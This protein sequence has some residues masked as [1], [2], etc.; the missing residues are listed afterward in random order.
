[1]PEFAKGILAKIETMAANAAYKEPSSSA[2]PQ[3]GRSSSLPERCVLEIEN[4]TNPSKF[5]LRRRALALT[6]LHRTKSFSASATTKV[7]R[8]AV[9][10]KV[11]PSSCWLG[12]FI[13]PGYVRCTKKDANDLGPA[14][15]NG[16]CDMIS[17]H[18]YPINFC[19]AKL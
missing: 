7:L 15:M 16:C 8:H 14:A 2:L 9:K 11:Q 3:I 1:M 13:L 17:C 10:Y 19:S 5:K 18:R 12:L 4:T 6:I